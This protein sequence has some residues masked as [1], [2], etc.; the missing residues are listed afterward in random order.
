MKF[1]LSKYLVLEHN[2]ITLYEKTGKDYKFTV[3]HFLGTNQFPYFIDDL[4]DGP[5]ATDILFYTL[6]DLGKLKELGKTYC[7]MSD[8]DFDKLCDIIAYFDNIKSNV[9]EIQ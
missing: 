1:N 8:T 7:N 5:K 9:Y 2:Y 6:E 3:G 4:I